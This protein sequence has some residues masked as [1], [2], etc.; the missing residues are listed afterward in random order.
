[1]QQTE[2]AGERHVPR[3]RA[4][5][6][7]DKTPRGNSGI[8][9]L[10]H[11][12]DVA[13]KTCHDYTLFRVRL[14]QAGQHPPDG[15]LRGCIA[16]LLGVRRVRKEQPDPVAGGQRAD[17]PEVCPTT[18][19]RRQ[20]QFEVAGVNDYPNRSVE[21]EREAMRDRVRYRDELDVERPNFPCLA[22]GYGDQLGPVEQAGFL[23]PVAGQA[24]GQLG[25][26]D[27]DAQLAKQVSERPAVVFVAMGK[28]AA[29]E[30]VFVLD[31]VREIGQ[32][33][34]D[35]EHFWFGEHDSAVHEDGPAVHFEPGAVPTYLT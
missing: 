31:D 23:D 4:A 22:I 17:A 35:T 26:I 19:H 5:Q 14:E 30:A 1:M 34:V 20:V 3:H 15:P 32:D 25:A 12:V 2:V 27:R 18:V 24:K 11:P 9:H 29:L 7:G 28:H 21:R 6:S 13:G 33:E 16:L 8:G 10:L